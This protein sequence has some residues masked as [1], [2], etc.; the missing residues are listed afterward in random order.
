MLLKDYPELESPEIQ[1]NSE[2]LVLL[3]ELDLLNYKT[4]VVV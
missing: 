1:S 3:E 2:M 4:E